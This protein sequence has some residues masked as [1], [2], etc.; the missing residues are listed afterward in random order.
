MLGEHVTSV[1]LSY[2]S[3][4]EQLKA[5]KLRALATASRTRIEPLP[6]VP[7]IVESGYKDIEVDAWAGL[8]APAKTTRETVSQLAGWFAAALLAPEIRSKLVVQVL[9]PVGTRGADFGAL[10][11]KQY[12]EFGRVIRESNIK[13]E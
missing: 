4:A 6:E 1:F 3:V 12:D 8:V 13:A 2:T 5:G 11:R 9:Y 7:T 10:L